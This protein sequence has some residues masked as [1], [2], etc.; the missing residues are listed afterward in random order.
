MQSAQGESLKWVIGVVVVLVA[1]YLYFGITRKTWNPF[2]GRFWSGKTSTSSTDCEKVLTVENGK[3]VT[4]CRNKEGFIWISA[5]PNFLGLSQIAETEKTKIQSLVSKLGSSSTR[6]SARKELL[7]KADVLRPL[8]QCARPDM[9]HCSD[10]DGK[11]RIWYNTDAF[12]YHFART[13]LEKNIELSDVT[14]T[15]IPSSMPSDSPDFT[16]ETIEEQENSDGR[17]YKSVTGIKDPENTTGWREIKTV[18]DL[19]K[20][21]NLVR[22]RFV[23]CFTEDGKRKINVINEPNDSLNQ[24]M[25]NMLTNMTFDFPEMKSPEVTIQTPT[26]KITLIVHI[27]IPYAVFVGWA[28]MKGMITGIWPDMKF[29][30][31][32]EDSNETI[33]DE[34]S[35]VLF[36]NLVTKLNKIGGLSGNSSGSPVPSSM[37]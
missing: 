8:V 37:S 22:K 24:E 19:A 13:I 21:W 33:E 9:L 14:C 35:G 16:I 5:N 20:L 18:G 1:I 30:D 12:E 6:E 10:K 31:E 3:L 34:H 28:M 25:I 17:K 26:G 15:D 36:Y 32:K 29:L 23:S 2:S 27:D 4:V 11:I 7:E